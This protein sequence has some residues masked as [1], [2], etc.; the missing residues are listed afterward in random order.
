MTFQY[1][2]RCGNIIEFSAQVIDGTCVSLSSQHI[3][4]DEKCPECQ[5]PIDWTGAQTDAVDAFYDLEA[6][7]NNDRYESYRDSGVY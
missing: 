1:L 4:K 2:C 6:D 3:T 5:T 7:K